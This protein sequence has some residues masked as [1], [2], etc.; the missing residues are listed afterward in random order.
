MPAD[1][2]KYFQVE[3]PPPGITIGTPPHHRQNLGTQVSLIESSKQFGGA[4][5]T[6]PRARAERTVA[7]SLISG[8]LCYPWRPSAGGGIRP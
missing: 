7:N 8:C 1:L 4:G 6:I 3:P 5:W 2:A